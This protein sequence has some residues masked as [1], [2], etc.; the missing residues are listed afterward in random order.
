MLEG[1]ILERAEEET[2]RRIG[3]FIHALTGSQAHIEYEESDGEAKLP[4]SCQPDPP[5]GWVKGED[6]AWNR[7][8]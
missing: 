6:G 2:T 4:P 1:G 8:S 5:S 3:N 7:A